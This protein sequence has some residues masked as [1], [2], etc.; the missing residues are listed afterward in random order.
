M[1]EPYN[2]L[3][4]LDKEPGG[5]SHDVVAQV[6][7]VLG[8]RSVGHCGTLDPMAGGLL[9]L[10]IGEGTKL[11]HYI[12][13]GDKSYRLKA[14]FGLRTDTLDTTGQ[15]LSESEQRPTEAQVREAAQALVGDFEWEVPQYSAV[16]VQGQRLHEAARRGE[17]IQAPVK[18]MRF[19]DLKIL[20][21]GSDEAEFEIHCS[22]G[23]YIRTW[24]S[25]LGE[26]LGCGAAMSG[27]RRLSSF[28][29]GVDQASTLDRVKDQWDRRQLSSS[30]VPLNRALP[31]VKRVRI[32][33]TDQTLLMNGQIS[34]DLRAQLISQFRPGAD[35]LLQI[36]SREDQ[37]L[38]LVGVEKGKGFTIRRVFRP[39]NPSGMSAKPLK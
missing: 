17:D 24:V 36:H 27:L 28:P 22:K 20:G 15:V 26:R 4:L 34:H 1:S 14:R 2:G 13:E 30:F 25:K 19:W 6:R 7:R 29:F 33:G 12:L 11:S 8:T 31:N 32:Q 39:E 35:E 16:K 10:L 18:T 9:V 21:I 37:L 23:S 38:A 3:L 5:T